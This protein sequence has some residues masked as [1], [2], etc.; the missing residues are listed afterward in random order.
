MISISELSKLAKKLTILYVEDEGEVQSSIKDILEHIFSN[1]LVASNGLEGIKISNDYHIDLILSDINMPHCNGLDMIETIK[2]SYPDVPTILLTGHERSD[3]L[4]RSI[5]LRVNKYLLKPVQKNLLFEALEEA[6]YIVE[7]KRKQRNK[8]LGLSKNLKMI[9]I[10]KLL[11]NITHQWRQ[12]LS[13]MSTSV[14]A[15]MLNENLQIKD[16]SIQ[17]LLNNIDT[18]IKDMDCLLENVFQDFEKDYKSENIH[19]YVV[20]NKLLITLKKDLD[21]SNIKLLINC[22][23]DLYIFSNIQSL[24]QIIHNIIENSIDAIDNYKKT[25]GTINIFAYLRNKECI[26][27][28][29][30]NGGGILNI[31]KDDIF[32]PYTTTKHSYIGTGL[33]LYIAYILTTKSLNGNI[34]NSN[35]SIDNEKC[36]KITIT[37][38]VI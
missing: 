20:L 27:E 34:I 10:A 35:I 23:D 4:L 28:I 32:E 26:I 31:I 12:S 29:I 11:D 25:D 37:I 8:Q 18:T 16:E 14:G 2:K 7:R 19:L 36:T 9:A 21:K 13:I 3:F 22:S 33:G 5:D 38:P 17:Y 6:L 1:V 15:I 30:D 24:T